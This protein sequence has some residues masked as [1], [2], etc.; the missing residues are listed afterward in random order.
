MGKKKT[1]S[2]IV[3]TV[4]EYGMKSPRLAS[5]SIFQKA[6]V[7]QKYKKTLFFLAM[8]ASMSIDLI[9]FVWEWKKSESH[10]YI[11]KTRIVRWWCENNTT[12]AIN[13]A[14]IANSI[15]PMKS[16]NNHT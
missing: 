2:G 12:F 6:A 10:M 16:Y 1:F 14:I 11:R 3:L 13:A 7:K 8:V 4:Y 5:T 9:L 15:M